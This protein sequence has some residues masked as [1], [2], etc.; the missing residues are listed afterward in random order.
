MPQENLNH[1]Y[2]AGKYFE[3]EPEQTPKPNAV[4][5]T[6][7]SNV[8]RKI[9]VAKAFMPEQEDPFKKKVEA[10]LKGIEPESTE[11]FGEAKEKAPDTENLESNGNCAV[12]PLEGEFDPKEFFSDTNKNVKIWAG[13]SF[14]NKVLSSSGN[15]SE[16]PPATTASFTLG[17]V[18][19]DTEIRAELPKNHVFSQDDLWMIADLIKKQPNGESGDLLADG[20]SNIFYVQADTSVLVVDMYWDGSGWSV[21][22]WALDADGQWLGGFRVFSRNG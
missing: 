6:K 3:P 2:N 22:D 16:Q 19:N 11:G 12:G 4:P 21:R 20:K 1:I 9:N 5:E 7:P 8:K 15:V 17:K 13:A 10:V 14:K 18:M